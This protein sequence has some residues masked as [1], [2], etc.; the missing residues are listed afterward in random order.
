MA[1]INIEFPAAK[2]NRGVPPTGCRE[3]HSVIADANVTALSTFI[4]NNK[5]KNV[6]LA[7]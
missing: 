1:M 6:Y 5:T 7:V 4:I 2:S 3:L